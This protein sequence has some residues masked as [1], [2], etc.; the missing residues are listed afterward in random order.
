MYLLEVANL[1][2]YAHMSYRVLSCFGYVR[3]V[4]IVIFISRYMHINKPP[5]NDNG[6]ETCHENCI[7][8]TSVAST[9][10]TN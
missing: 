3:F 8:I 5:D 10:S 7:S 2:V 1:C 9:I 4:Q 6:V